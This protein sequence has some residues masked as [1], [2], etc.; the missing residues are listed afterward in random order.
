MYGYSVLYYHLVFNNLRLSIYL[1]S[2]WDLRNPK[3]LLDCLRLIDWLPYVQRS[4]RPSKSF[5]PQ[6]CFSC[7]S[8]PTNVGSYLSTLVSEDGTHVRIVEDSDKSCLGP[9]RVYPFR[10]LIGGGTLVTLTLQGNTWS[11]GEKGFTVSPEFKKCAYRWQYP[12]STILHYTYRISV[13][14]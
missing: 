4:F 1:E 5:W 10:S 12:S 13:N 9:S 3:S 7:S 6:H 11:S 14:Q 2:S 8:R